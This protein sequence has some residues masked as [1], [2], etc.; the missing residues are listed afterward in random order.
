MGRTP[1]DITNTELAVLQTLWDHGAATIRQLTERLY[2]GGG[3]TK[4]ATIQKLLE[5][6]EE[7]GHVARDRGSEVSRMF[8]PV[9][10]DAE[11]AE[12]AGDAGLEQHLRTLAH[13]GRMTASSELGRGTEMTLTLP[14]A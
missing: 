5:R 4:Y 13:G 3:T 1:Q 12:P 2:P 11:M 6:L 7:D 14:L 10:I 8:Q 9:Q